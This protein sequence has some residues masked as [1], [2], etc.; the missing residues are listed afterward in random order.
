MINKI[1]KVPVTKLTTEQ[2][3]KSLGSLPQW[4]YEN[5][6]ISKEYTLGNFEQTWV[7]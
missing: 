7:S 1:S 6:E 4:R 5:N 2:I 3:Q